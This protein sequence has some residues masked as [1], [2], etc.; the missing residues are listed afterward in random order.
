MSLI[1]WPIHRIMVDL[2]KLSPLMNALC[3]TSRSIGNTT[4]ATNVLEPHSRF[5]LARKVDDAH[6]CT[7]PSSIFLWF[8]RVVPRK[9]VMRE[10]S[11]CLFRGI[12]ALGVL[13]QLFFRFRF[14][15]L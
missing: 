3:R 8:V 5:E 4:Y 13:M 7:S 9:L 6:R 15:F 12:D 2:T 10:Q 1:V 11:K 14:R